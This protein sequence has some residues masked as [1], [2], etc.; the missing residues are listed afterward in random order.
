MIKYLL[1]VD[2]IIS[3]IV[4]LIY[5]V[6]NNT[7]DKISYI[8]NNI[9]NIYIISTIERYILYLIIHIL[10]YILLI[11][12]IDL[13]Y[14]Y[15]IFAIPLFQN[16]IFSFY[17]KYINIYYS[18]KELAI[19]YIISK[20]LLIYLTSLD[21]K[22]ILYNDYYVYSLIKCIDI[23]YILN[24]FKSF[25]VIN[26][27]LFLRNTN[28]IFY[29]ILKL[30]LYNFL[31]INLTLFNYDIAIIKIN[32][33]ISNTNWK[34]LS[35]IDNTL[36]LSILIS[37]NKWDFTQFINKSLFKY[38]LF[39]SYWS[40]ISLFNYIISSISNNYI[41]LL[42]LTLQIYLFIN[43]NSTYM[44][45]FNLKTIL[46]FILIFYDI[47]PLITTVIYVLFNIIYNIIYDLSYFIYNF[48]NILNNIKNVNNITHMD[49]STELVINDKYI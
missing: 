10:N 14:L 23:D 20:Q 4:F 46:I 42:F 47:N 11:L 3:S 41:L 37:K 16:Y 33:I 39:T 22:I 18:Y 26:F 19:K 27:M 13:T 49:I 6:F 43:T 15:L 29:K 44:F 8:L 40:L 45:K 17:K 31:N 30:G 25:L 35:D 9:N 1:F 36:A 32:K 48:V 2:N 21:N 34:S 24:I 38:T 12:N 5:S 28:Y 7:D